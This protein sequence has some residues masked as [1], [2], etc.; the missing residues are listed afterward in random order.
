MLLFFLSYF[1]KIVD[2][3]YSF[4]YASATDSENYYWPTILLFTVTTCITEMLYGKRW[5]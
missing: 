2:Q 3:Y 1:S 5:S 4:R